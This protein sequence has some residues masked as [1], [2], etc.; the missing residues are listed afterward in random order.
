MSIQYDRRGWSDIDMRDPHGPKA[1]S[2]IDQPEDL[3]KLMAQ[4]T[5]ARCLAASATAAT[6]L[7]A[8]VGRYMST[9]RDSETGYRL[10]L[11]SHGKGDADAARARAQQQARFALNAAVLDIKNS[12]THAL[13]KN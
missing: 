4:R 3:V 11:R 10:T 8:A 6:A 13:D 7:D 9:L 12:F 5:R 1:A 2:E